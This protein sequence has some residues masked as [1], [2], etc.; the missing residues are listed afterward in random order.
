MFLRGRN[1]GLARR[2]FKLNIM[3]A[4]KLFPASIFEIER[5]EIY[6]KLLTLVRKD[7][8]IQFFFFILFFFL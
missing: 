4:W 1:V 5:S 6:F 2:N 8:L 3:A 7:K